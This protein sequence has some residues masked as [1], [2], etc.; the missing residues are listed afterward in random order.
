MEHLTSKLLQNAAGDIYPCH[1][2]GHKR[3]AHGE[4]PEALF[5]LDITEVDGFDNL[6]MPEEI[7]L[8]LQKK[9]SE[10][11]GAEE[12]FYLVNGSTCGILSAVSVV[13]PE[14][15]RLLMARNC[16]KSAYHAAYLRGLNLSYLYPEPVEAYDF[17]DAVTPKQVEKALEKE[18]FDAVLIVSPTYEGR[19]AEIRTIAEIVHK[20]GIPLIVDEAHGAHLGLGKG[21]WENSC[22]LGADLVIHSVHKTLP[23]LTQ[24]ALLHVNGNRVDREKLRRFL[25][26]YQSS[27]PSY[28]LMASIDNALTFVEEEGEG[29]Y[30][31][32]TS[33]FAQMT[34]K[35][36]A[37]R[38]LRILTGEKALQDVGKLVISVKNTG[39]SGNQLYHI[40][41]EE[42]HIQ[43]EMAAESYALAMFTI[44]DGPEGYE[45][46][47][48]ALLAIDKRLDAGEYNC[49]DIKTTDVSQTENPV[50]QPAVA[51]TLTAA[52]DG[53]TEDVTLADSIGRV[54]GEFV[55]LYPPGIPVLVPGE[56]IDES[57]IQNVHRWLALELNVQGLKQT[58]S[59]IFVKVLTI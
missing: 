33:R 46:M 18:T 40:L 51:T 8:D 38:K 43:L 58:E 36:R 59:E 25:R 34:E 47:E 45:R 20:K 26:I 37:C 28:V 31:F 3:R 1:M 21:V 9:A 2:P 12:T 10:L 35:L 48:Q 6:H 7:F 14:G 50:S 24:T 22:R 32:F 17:L 19:I 57:F 16:H 49:M 11:Y 56:V 27:S 55:N 39:I 52:W 5:G 41:L 44:G 4:L 30:E 53:K 15:G 13:V 29:A 42:F 54:A 23:S